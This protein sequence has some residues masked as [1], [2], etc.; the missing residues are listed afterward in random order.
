MATKK[1]ELIRNLTQTISKESKKNSGGNKELV[2][3]LQKLLDKVKK[4]VY[5]FIKVLLLQAFSNGEYTS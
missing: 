1:Q 3:K 5:L 4:S 2:E